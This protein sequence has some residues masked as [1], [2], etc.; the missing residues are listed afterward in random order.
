MWKVPEMWKGGD[1]WI[2]G[3][4][5]SL[6]QQ[7]NIPKKVVQ[8]VRKG[9][10]PLSAYSEYLKSLHTKHIIAVNMAFMLGNWV[11]MMFFGDPEF[12]ELCKND[13][14][15][16]RGIKI[17]RHSRFDAKKYKRKGIHYLQNS[18]I[19][20]GISN[21]SSEVIWNKNSGAAAI[22]IAALSGAK[23]II[24]VGFDM[25]LGEHEEQHWHSFYEQA[26]ATEAL[27]IKHLR[28]FAAIKAD[29]EK[30]GIEIINTSPISTI[31]EFKKQD[32]NELL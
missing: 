20:E 8:K 4:G 21:K 18:V 25:T 9:E 1:V 28:G 26:K 10:I 13:L 3:G 14:N 29:A 7:F 5:S 11:D 16:F 23:R 24:L 22:S 6:L 32:I 19:K 2:I 15:A 30:R 12:Y 31:T 27:F 17:A